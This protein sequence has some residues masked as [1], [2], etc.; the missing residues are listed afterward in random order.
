M[1]GEKRKTG[2]P[3][4][5][6]S[7]EPM[8]G[9]TP[10]FRLFV[11]FSLPDGVS[12]SRR[13]LPHWE[14]PDCTFFV[15]F[16]LADSLPQGKL[17][18]IKAERELWLQAHLEPWSQA[19]WDDYDNRFGERIQQWLDAGHGSC[20][21]ATDS[22]ARIVEDAL[23][24][25]DGERHVLDALVVMPNHVHV[26]LKPVHGWTLPKVEHSWKSFT[27]HAVN[28]ALARTGTF[29][30]EESFDRIVRSVEQLGYYQRYIRENPT[31]AGLRAGQFRLGSGLGLRIPPAA[32]GDG[33]TGVPPVEAEPVSGETPDLHLPAPNGKTGVPSVEAEP[34]SGETPDFHLPA[35]SKKETPVRK[36]PLALLLSALALPCAAAFEPAPFRFLKPLD[37]GARSREEILTTALDSEV[38]RAAAADYRDLRIVDD[39]GGEIPRL[40][41]KATAS[42]SVIVRDPLVMET[43]SLREFPDNRIEILFRIRPKE[44]AASGVQEAQPSPSGFTLHTPLRNFERTVTV[45]GSVDGTKWEPLVQ[46]AFIFDYSRYMDVANADVQLPANKCRQFKVE[47]SNVTDEKRSPFLELTREIRGG[48]E[49]GQIT[50]TTLE[51]RPLRIDR[52][53]FWVNVTHEE[54]RGDVKQSYPVARFE[55]RQ[56]PKKKA[57]IVDVYT[58]REPL[59]GFTLDTASRNFSRRVSVEVPRPGGAYADWRE[60]GSGTVTRLQFQSFSK[61]ELKVSFPE[62]RE[63]HY[64]LVIADADNPPLQITGLKAEGNVYRAVFLAYPKRGYRLFYGA[65]EM[66]APAYDLAPV[67]ALLRQGFQPLAGKLGAQAENPDYRRRAGW[68]RVLNHKAFLV[69]V[70]GVMVAVLAWG[71]YRTGRRVEALPKE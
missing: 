5:P 53:D 6:V 35:A 59:T 9:E 17:D 4:P 66:P 12:K 49:Q 23:Q 52:V 33:K 57:T 65:E 21:L 30:M 31:N 26:I 8:S 47:I 51:Q 50:K 32:S 24:H 54:R 36:L 25:F 19:E 38:F 41:E 18:E 42:K 14:Q 29:W 61:D 58:S 22:I 68:G 43:V 28:Q 45:A 34:V 70:I 55:A 2:V 56:D 67:L 16:R 64:R 1:P 27:A 15:T 46:E 40:V 13:H 10:D 71:L 20:V 48:A 60:A 39:A 44:A 63:E 62:S 37:A 69:A 11:P 7:A 3:P